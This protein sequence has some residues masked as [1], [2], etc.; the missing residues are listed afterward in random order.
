MRYEWDGAKAE[1]NLAKH[2]VP[3]EDVA[4]FDWTRA[5]VVADRR[6]DYREMRYVSIGPIASRIHVLIFTLRTGTVRVIS[7]RKANARERIF[8][9]A[10]T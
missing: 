10:Q 5:F 4:G 3:F 9:E 1:A 7:L 8:Y 2:G 6:R